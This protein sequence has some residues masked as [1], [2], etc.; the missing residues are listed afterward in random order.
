MQDYHINTVQELVWERKRLSEWDTRKEIVNCRFCLC[1]IPSVITD[2]LFNLFLIYNLMKLKCLCPGQTFVKMQPL[3]LLSF[4]TL[5]LKMLEIGKI[6]FSARETYVHII[7]ILLF[8]Q[9]QQGDEK[10]LYKSKI[11]V[12]TGLHK[13]LLFYKDLLNQWT[14]A[15]QCREQL[16]WIACS[17]YFDT[18]TF[19]SFLSHS[20]SPELIKWPLHS[21]LDTCT[22]QDFKSGILELLKS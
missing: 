20:F 9:Y 5:M 3:L 7:N 2:T 17:Q 4:L 14:A 16:P 22:T 19:I 21:G 12:A 10:N 1:Q 13:K 6:F 18:I 8:G 11:S 15:N